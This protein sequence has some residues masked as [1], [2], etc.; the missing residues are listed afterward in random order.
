MTIRPLRAGARMRVVEALPP[1]FDDIAARFDVRGK[2]I[3]FAVGDTIYNPEGVAVSEELMAHEHVHGVRQ[4]DDP[5]TWWRAYLASPSFRLQEEL[6]AHVAEFASLCR[7]HAHAWP[8]RRNMRR[9]LADH[10]GA[11]LA[12][13]LY[14][15]LVSR[16][17]A[18]RM[19][20]AG[21]RA[22][23]LEAA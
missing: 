16:D 22:L 17:R 14:G 9:A 5:L 1:L 3:L 10:V 20:L 8:N 13:P 6:A 11:K 7:Q 15:S 18:K 19:I 4:G 2:P 23:E 12:A 21:S